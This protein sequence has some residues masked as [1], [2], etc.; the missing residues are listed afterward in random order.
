MAEKPEVTLHLIEDRRRLGQRVL[1]QLR[2]Q[3]GGE[4]PGVSEAAS[5]WWFMLGWVTRGCAVG[6]VEDDADKVIGLFA[7]FTTATGESKR[8]SDDA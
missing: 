2:R 7:E 5:Q 3:V 8:R 4:P 1:A 6:M